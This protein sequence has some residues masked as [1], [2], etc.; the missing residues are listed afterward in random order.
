MPAYV[1][2]TT[3]PIRGAGERIDPASGYDPSDWTHPEPVDAQKDDKL[4]EHRD[5]DDHGTIG[6]GKAEERKEQNNGSA[7]HGTGH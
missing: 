7:G 5:S 4:G 1:K 2:P 3:T 6:R